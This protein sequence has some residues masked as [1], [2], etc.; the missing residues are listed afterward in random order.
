MIKSN[1]ETYFDKHSYKG[2]HGRI[3]MDFE[4]QI[5]WI[6]NKISELQRE[7]EKMSS[8]EFKSD[9]AKELQNNMIRKFQSDINI[10]KIIMNDYKKAYKDSAELSWTKY[11]EQMGR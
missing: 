4:H 6:E 5:K 7:I 9:G 11:P 8:K 10:M 1:E 3:E 2:V